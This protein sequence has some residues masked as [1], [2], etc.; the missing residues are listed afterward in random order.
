M[1]KVKYEKNYEEAKVISQSSCATHDM[2]RVRKTPRVRLRGHRLAVRTGSLVAEGV[3]EEG[4]HFI[5]IPDTKSRHGS[6]G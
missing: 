6:H 4:L 3:I 5:L 2:W 1:Y